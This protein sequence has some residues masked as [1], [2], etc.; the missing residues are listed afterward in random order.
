MRYLVNAFF[1]TD[2]PPTTTTTVAGVSSY[3]TRLFLSRH[4]TLLNFGLLLYRM[5]HIYIFHLLYALLS[6]HPFLVSVYS[7]SSA[8]TATPAR[9]RKGGFSWFDLLVYGLIFLVV[10]VPLSALCLAS[11]GWG[12]VLLLCSCYFRVFNI[13]WNCKSM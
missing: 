11:M 13:F 10:C 9:E 7:P 1:P 8:F 12:F 3:P 2:Q 6:H 5:I 4:P